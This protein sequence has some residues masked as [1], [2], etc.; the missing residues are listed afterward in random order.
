M[1]LTGKGVIVA[2]GAGSIGRAVVEH[3][4]RNGAR[5]AVLDSD[6]EGARKFTDATVTYLRA[7]A[8]DEQAVAQAVAAAVA[9]L[10]EIHVLVNCTGMI[11]SEPLIT[12]TDPQRRRHEVPNW[13]AV[14]RSNLTATFVVSLYVAEHMVTNRI[15]GVIVNFSSIAA[16]GNPG[17]TAY[18]AA[19]AGVEAMTVV[20]ARELGSLGIRVLAIAPGF[21]DTPSTGAALSASSLQELKR[22]TPLRRLATVQEIAQTVSFAIENDFVTGRTISIDGGL[23]L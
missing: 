13:D 6:P 18:A 8:A 23:T 22:R 12:L 5:V 20:W 21:V 15:K 4:S 19:K 10:G 2:G 7:D 14:I 3:L 11:H 1:E 9:T 16:A 17:Q